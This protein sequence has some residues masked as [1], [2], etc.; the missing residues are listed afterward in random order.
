MEPK[1][2]EQK[3]LESALKWIEAAIL[4]YDI[5]AL[6]TETDQ[7]MWDRAAEILEW[8]DCQLCGRRCPEDEG[9]WVT[10]QQASMAGP[11]ERE[12]ICG[13]HEDDGDNYGD[14]GRD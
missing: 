12:W 14:E 11:E 2:R 10:I 7:E 8:P 3:R 5:R 4:E 6:E 9:S 13:R 1:T